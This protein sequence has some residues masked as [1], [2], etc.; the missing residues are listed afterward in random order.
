M[1]KTVLILTDDK[2]TLIE[3]ETFDDFSCNNGQDSPNLNR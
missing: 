2:M 1:A 3:Y